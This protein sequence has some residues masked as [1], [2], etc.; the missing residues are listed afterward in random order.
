[1]ERGGDWYQGVE[2]WRRRRIGEGESEKGS[3]EGGGGGG[4]EGAPV[5]GREGGI[6]EGAR[7][8]KGVGRR[9]R[10]KD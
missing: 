8:G 6:R 2:R 3:L 7:E 1:M 10:E 5:R 9:G 4:R